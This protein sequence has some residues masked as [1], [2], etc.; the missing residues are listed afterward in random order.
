MAPWKVPYSTHST[1]EYFLKWWYPI[2][3]PFLDGIVHEMNHLAIGV[4]P[5]METP[6]FVK[7]I[8][9]MIFDTL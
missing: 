1:C 3:H 7:L 9:L 8:T 6:R 4:S 5:F 2:Y